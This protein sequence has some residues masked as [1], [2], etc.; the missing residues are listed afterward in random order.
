[1]FSGALHSTDGCSAGIIANHE[2]VAEDS[3]EPSFA[4]I[5]L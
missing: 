3:E 4:R 1:M 5:K 2:N